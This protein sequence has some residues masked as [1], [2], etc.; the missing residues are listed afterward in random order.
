MENDTPKRLEETARVCPK[1]EG[2]SAEPCIYCSHVVP[3]GIFERPDYNDILGA[4]VA[5]RGKNQ[6]AIRSSAPTYKMTD[7]RGFRIYYVWRL[8]RHFQGLDKQVVATAA[9]LASGDPWSP[10]LTELAKVLSEKLA[11][12]ADGASS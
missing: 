4:L 5:Q 8:F 11:A 3:N 6:G 10:E 1:C 9:F 12:G 7:L 2:S